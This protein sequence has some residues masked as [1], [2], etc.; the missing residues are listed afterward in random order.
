MN[1]KKGYLKGSGR[2]QEKGRSILG[3]MEGPRSMQELLD[4]G[5]TNKESDSSS[6][7]VE[8]KKNSDMDL[9]F[10]GNGQR[11]NVAA[12]KTEKVIEQAELKE[13]LAR[14]HIEYRRDLEDA[15]LTEVFRRKRDKNMRDAKRAT[16]RAVVE[17]ALAL[18]LKIS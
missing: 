6:K 16:Q 17:E 12:V 9:C 15:L 13:D 4:D 1:G 10:S 3:K 7:D 5:Q 14:L 18:F 2:F 11:G 8:N